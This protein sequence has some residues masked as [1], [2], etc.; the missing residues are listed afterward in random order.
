MNEN[1][2]SETSFFYFTNGYSAYHSAVLGST[3]YEHRQSRY[4]LPASVK[5]FHLH[6][7]ICMVTL[8][9]VVMLCEG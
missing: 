9:G 7:H 1:Q 4:T 3:S 6:T 8:N 2:N 5:N